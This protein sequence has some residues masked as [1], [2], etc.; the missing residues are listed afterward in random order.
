MLCLTGATACCCWP[1]QFG[2]RCELY[3]LI[4]VKPPILSSLAMV[5]SSQ[6]SKSSIF[7][8][9]LLVFFLQSSSCRVCCLL[10]CTKAPN[11]V[12]SDEALL[13]L[14]EFALF[15]A[16]F[17]LFNPFHVMALA[18]IL[19]FPLAHSHG[20]ARPSIAL[21]FLS[22]DDD[23]ATHYRPAPAPAVSFCLQEQR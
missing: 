23:G 21:Q 8:N 17:F 12:A 20:S 1:L 2:G 13:L 3:I 9:N 5:A 7:R 18:F 10:L 22:G 4:Y 14:F 19:P 6:R 11:G 15:T 16:P